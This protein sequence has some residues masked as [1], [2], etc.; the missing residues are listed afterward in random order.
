MAVVI[1]T[2]TDLIGAHP[3]APNIL[4]VWLDHNDYAVS[5][6]KKHRGLSQ[7]IHANRPNVI[8][9]F[10]RRLIHHHIDEIR[11]DRLKQKYQQLNYPQYAAANRKLPT[12]DRTKKGNAIEILLIEYI[13]SCQ[14]KPLIKHFKLRYNGNVDQS[15]KGDD[16][17][18]VDVIK[19]AQNNDTVKVF[20]GESKFRATPTA[21]IVNEISTALAAS[22]KPLSY[23]FLVDELSRD[24][25]TK[26]IADMLDNFIVD[27]I[28]LQGNITYTGLL[29]SDI[30]ASRYVENNLS[31]ANDNLV[32][33]SFGIDNP[34]A[35]IN[36]AFAAAEH[37]ILNPHLI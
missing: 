15:M 13:E 10:A 24:P 29:V 5:A 1:K 7:N 31:N 34:T 19:D 14:G 12:A 35:L 21:A 2:Q 23:T 16:M 6:T 18:L 36:D 27:Q 25:A 17:L 4:G 3:A 26:S 22:K 28:K 8:D 37:L 9:W 30:N 11:L 20:L 33:L 32:V